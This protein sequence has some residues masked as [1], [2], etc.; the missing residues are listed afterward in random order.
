MID[1]TLA[2]ARDGHVP[3]ITTFPIL[4]NT[5]TYCS[6]ILILILRWYFSD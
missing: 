5:S 1:S 4:A 3:T 6:L 2:L